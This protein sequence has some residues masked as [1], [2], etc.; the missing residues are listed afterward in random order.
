MHQLSRRNNKMEVLK[1]SSKSKPNSVAGALANALRERSTVEIQA[2]GAGSLNQAIKAIAIARGYVAPSGKDLICIPAFS[3][4]IID[5]EE[6]TAIKLI[7]EAR[8]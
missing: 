3:D 8:K 2:I 5:G 1:V 4:I 6:R 7:V